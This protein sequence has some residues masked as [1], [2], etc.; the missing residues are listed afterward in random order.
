MKLRLL[1]IP[2]LPLALFSCDKAKHLAES[3]TK[4]VKQELASKAGSASETSADPELMK[5][6]DQNAEGVLF[7][8]DLPFPARVD[9]RIRRVDDLAV[10]MMQSSEIGRQNGMVKGIREQVFKLERAGDQVRITEERSEFLV[11]SVDDPE[12]TKKTENPLERAAPSNKPVTFRKNGPNWRVE[13]G[14]D[15]RSAVLEK[16]LSPVFDMLLIEH[17]L[18]PRPLWFGKQRMKPGDTL[19]VTGEQLP[20]LLVG[21]KGTF[22]LKY[23]SIEPVEGH[24][25]G[26]F[27]VTG[28]FSR[29]KFPD[30]EGN[31][32]DEDVTIQSGRVW[33][34]LLHPLI[35]KEDFSTIQS[36]KSGGQGNLVGRAQGAVK[37][38]VVREWKKM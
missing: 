12:V 28:D 18:S 29:R 26:V 17:A 21:G 37:H 22:N 35:L 32:T 9:V 13:N 19:V 25:C 33:L 11:P 10:R 2:C 3:A 20:M 1:A 7:R 6:V 23:E 8:K 34:S 38:S 5:L 15:F 36:F 24:P 14:G 27:A 16:E 31:L 30:L 4:T